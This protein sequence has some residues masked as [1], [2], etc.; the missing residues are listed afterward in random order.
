MT[1]QYEFKSIVRDTG[2]GS[3]A[4][5]IPKRDLKFFGA[6]DKVKKGTK[7]KVTMEV[8]EDLEQND[9]RI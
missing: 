2:G 7:V 4:I 8:M 3:L 1:Q 9:S 5:G 6:L